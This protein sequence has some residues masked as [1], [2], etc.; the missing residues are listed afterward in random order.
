MKKSPRENTN[1]PVYSVLGSRRE[2]FF[3]YGDEGP[4]LISVGCKAV[5]FVLAS[6]RHCPVDFEFSKLGL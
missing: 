2:V 5:R 6:P 3:G 4:V 1:R